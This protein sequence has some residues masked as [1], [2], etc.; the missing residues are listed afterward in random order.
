MTN[1]DGVLLNKVH[2]DEAQTELRLSAELSVFIRV[3]PW[4]PGQ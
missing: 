3:H 1:S 2:P 4:Q